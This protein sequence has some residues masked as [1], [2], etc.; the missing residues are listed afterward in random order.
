MNW[1]ADVLKQIRD[2]GEDEP[3]CYQ[4]MIRAVDL[5][6]ICDKHVPLAPAPS[7]ARSAGDFYMGWW[8]RDAKRTLTVDIDKKCTSTLLMRD[9]AHSSLTE[10]CDFEVLKSAV[11]NFFDGWKPR[12]AMEVP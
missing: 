11:Q 2:C 9:G 6:E 7:I 10:R 12:D 1:L 5:S 4:M 8:W 3:R